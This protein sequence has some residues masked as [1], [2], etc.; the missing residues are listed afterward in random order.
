MKGSV[1]IFK[2]LAALT[3]QTDR[4]ENARVLYTFVALNQWSRLSISDSVVR[5]FITYSGL[6]TFYCKPDQKI[7]FFPSFK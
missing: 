6:V 5:C 7:D 4:A 2:N 3:K 1:S